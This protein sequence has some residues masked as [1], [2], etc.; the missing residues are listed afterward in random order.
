MLAALIAVLGVVPIASCGG[1]GGGGGPTPI[2]PSPVPVIPN[3]A[4]SWTGNYAVSSCTN[5]GFF[6]DVTF[7]ASVNDSTAAAAFTLSQN[8]RS[9]SGTFSLGT[10]NSPSVTA[11]IGGDDTLVL[12]ASV[13]EGTFTIATTWTLRILTSSALSGQ[14]RQVWTLAGQSGEAVLQGSIVSVTRT[15]G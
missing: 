4:G 14:T 8:E 15:G 9:V 13:Q 5:S 3:F 10:L 11:V 12:T 1:G 7:C 2:G 6:A